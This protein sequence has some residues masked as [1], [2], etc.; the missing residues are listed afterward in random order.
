[1]AHD[2]AKLCRHFSALSALACRLENIGRLVGHK[3]AGQCI[4]LAWARSVPQKRSENT[5]CHGTLKD[6]APCECLCAGDPCGSDAHRRE[7][8]SVTQNF[9]GETDGGCGGGQV[10]QRPYVLDGRTQAEG[11]CGETPTEAEQQS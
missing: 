6:H 10:S 7:A 1:M 2:A 9:S 11:H 4:Q 3:E 5:V 8:I